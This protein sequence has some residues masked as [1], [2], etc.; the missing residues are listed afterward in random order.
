M[1]GSQSKYY[2][3]VQTGKSSALSTNHVYLY[4]FN[5]S[6]AVVYKKK[7]L[8]G[9]KMKLVLDKVFMW[10]ETAI[11]DV[12]DSDH[13]NTIKVMRYPDTFLFKSEIAED[14]RIFM[15]N[16]KLIMDGLAYEKKKETLFIAQKIHDSTFSIDAI[17]D[18]NKHNTN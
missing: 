12:K 10:H 13:Q 6:I 15:A 14:K 11:I 16:V 7:A 3:I 1:D 2:E 8:I 17:E 9:N 4:Q 18:G 5:D